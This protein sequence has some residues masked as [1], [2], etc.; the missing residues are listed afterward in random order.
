MACVPLDV[1]GTQRLLAWP[2][3]K[4]PGGYYV[5]GICQ[6]DVAGCASDAAIEQAMQ[7]EDQ[8]QRKSGRG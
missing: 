7:D 8:G 3:L 5:P 1:S 2:N 4:N 6:I